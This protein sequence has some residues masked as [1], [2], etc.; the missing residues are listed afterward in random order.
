M[1]SWRCTHEIDALRVVVT[2]YMRDAPEGSRAVHLG[3][4]TRVGL[5]LA[6]I[7]VVAIGLL[8]TVTGA[9]LDWT[10]EAARTLIAAA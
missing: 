3:G 1:R 9:I 6:A 5:V 7:G 10:M 8:P 4:W 2:M